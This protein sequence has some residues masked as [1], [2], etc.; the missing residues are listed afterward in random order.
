M[1][2]RTKMEIMP[3]NVDLYK[4]LSIDDLERRLELSCYCAINL[5]GGYCCELCGGQ[6]SFCSY[7]GG[8]EICNTM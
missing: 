5:C 6:C 3:L 8:D 2:D 7:C 4:D 1:D